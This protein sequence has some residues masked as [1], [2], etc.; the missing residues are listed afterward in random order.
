MEKVFGISDLVVF[1]CF[2]KFIGKW[3]GISIEIIGDF[4][5]FVIVD[6]LW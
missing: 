1:W 2:I 6:V 5:F 3:L 4:N